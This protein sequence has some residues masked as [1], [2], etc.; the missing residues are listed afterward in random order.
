MCGIVGIVNKGDCVPDLY[1]ALIVLQHRGQDAAGMA[2]YGREREHPYV[3]R[4]D[5]GQVRDVFKKKHIRR[6]SGGTMGIGHVR[7]PTAGDMA[8][9]AMQGQ[10]FFVNSPYGISLAH[11]GNLTNTDRLKREVW[12]DDRR[13]V[14]TNSDSEVLLNV[15]AHELAM[16]GGRASAAEIFRA[17][18]RVHK[19]VIGA[20]AAVAMINGK[21]IVGFRDSHGIRPLC[22]GRR[23]L[24]EGSE[25]MFASESVALSVNGFRLERD[26]AP[27]EA[28]FISMDGTVSASLYEGGVS[29]TPCIF[30]YVYLARPDSLIENVSVKKARMRMGLFLAEKIKK[31][32]RGLSVDVVIPVPDT[33]RDIAVEMALALGITYREGFVKNRYMPRTFIMPRQKEREASVRRKLNPMELEFRGKN[34]MLVDDSIVR[35]T[36]SKK[37]IEMVRHVG[38]K[39]V[40]FVSAAPP[41]RFPNIYGIDMPSAKEL[42]AAEKSIEDVKNYIGADTLIYGDLA[43]LEKAVAEGNPAL[44]QFETS[45]FT[46][47]YVTG[48]AK[49]YLEKIEQDRADNKRK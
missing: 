1:D 35:G 5:V 14:V 18:E 43:D 37:I 48:V 24:P 40:H 31:E 28:V 20:Y 16:Q 17:A 22:Y 15:F 8:N 13:F 26:I 12:R 9:T 34:V 21:G 49:E 44:Q 2:T 46:G 7:Y 3:L 33:S 23:D 42:I 32:Y 4:K 45:I 41:I 11:N 6:L 25:Y 29:H 38:A 36:T 27:G 30:E 19:R 39:Q 10:P 47:H